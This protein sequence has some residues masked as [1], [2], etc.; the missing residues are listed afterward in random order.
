MELA[1]TMSTM[2]AT[3]TLEVACEMRR[4][5]WGVGRW[6]S[7]ES[8]HIE[9]HVGEREEIDEAADADECV[10]EPPLGVHAVPSL[11]HLSTAPTIRTQRTLGVHCTVLYCTNPLY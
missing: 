9:H 5:G 2:L 6:V 7:G 3:V 10:Q 11:P 8:T 1:L 4:R